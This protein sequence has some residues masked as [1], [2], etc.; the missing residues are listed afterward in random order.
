MVRGALLTDIDNT[1]FSW[2]DFFAPSFRA[3][4]H[5][6][7]RFLGVTEDRLYDEFKQVYAEH[8]SLEYAFSIQE[9]PVVLKLPRERQHDAVRIGRGAFSSVYRTHLKP[10]PAVVETLEWAQE[11]GLVVAAV[12]NSPAYLAQK[13][14]YDLKLDRIIKVLIAWEGFRAQTEGSVV[15]GFV[16]DGTHLRDRSRVSRVVI[17]P[18]SD[19]KPNDAHYKI[20]LEELGIDPDHSWVIGDSLQKDLAPAGRLGI[21][22]IWAKYGTSEPGRNFET[23][24]RITHWAPDKIEATYHDDEFEPEFAIN[25]I[26]E[27]KH[28]LPKRQLTLF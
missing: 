26:E 19:V 5:A 4:V 7:A 27:L 11:Q 28:I 3:M 25:Q 18:E 10:Y 2:Q 21:H 14:L 24:L 16:R 1:L 8:A 6:L 23:L 13:R 22:T 12:T 17:V 9:L 15:A 20:A